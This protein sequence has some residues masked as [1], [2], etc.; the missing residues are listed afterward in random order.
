MCKS[1]QTERKLKRFSFNATQ[2]K[3]AKKALKFSKYSSIAF[4]HKSWSLCWVLDLNLCKQ[5]VMVKST[6]DLE[7]SSPWK[8]KCSNHVFQIK[9]HL[10]PPNFIFWGE[11][12]VGG[13]HRNENKR[14]IIVKPLK[15]EI[16][17]PP[18]WTMDQLMVR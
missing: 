11:Q 13:N 1:W 2:T 4:S 9:L 3:Q 5:L 6:A 10:N 18:L 16:K 17:N 14:Q 12:R 7:E 8:E 15:D